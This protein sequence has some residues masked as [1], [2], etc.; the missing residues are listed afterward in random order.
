MPLVRSDFAFISFSFFAHVAHAVG[1]KCSTQELKG[2]MDILAGLGIVV[3]LLLVA[4]LV[5]T[6]KIVTLR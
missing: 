4:A 1:A 5:L 2:D 3:E 6:A